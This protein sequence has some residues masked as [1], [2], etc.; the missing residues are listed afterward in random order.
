[1]PDDAN[2]NMMM[3]QAFNPVLGNINFKLEGSTRG[4]VQATNPTIPY[5]SLE[6]LAYQQQ[7]APNQIRTGQTLGTQNVQGQQ[8]V[9][10]STGNVRIL[11]GYSQGAF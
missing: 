9:T 5:L 11:M 7:I 6:A 3:Y 8:T 2:N 4:K 10:D 1:M